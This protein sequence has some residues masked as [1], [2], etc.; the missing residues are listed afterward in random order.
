[1]Q[2]VM[3][4]MIDGRGDDDDGHGNDDD[5]DDDCYDTA[6]YDTCLF[7]LVVTSGRVFFLQVCSWAVCCFFLGL[8]G[9]GSSRILSRLPPPAQCR[10]WS[11]K[12]GRS[13]IC[14]TGH[15]TRVAGWVFRVVL[16]VFRVVFLLI[17]VLY[18]LFTFPCIFLAPP[19]FAGDM[20]MIFP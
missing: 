12:S 1:M 8:V 11:G 16:D 10:G 9:D 6:S 3:V 15:A 2:I 18:P 17:F 7:G 20:A 5:D 14:G 4:M 13:F 19:P